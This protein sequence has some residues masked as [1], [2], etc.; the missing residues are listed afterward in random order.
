MILGFM[1][2]KKSTNIMNGLIS[3]LQTGKSDDIIKL[4]DKERQ[5]FF[6]TSDYFQLSSVFSILI[7]KF[8]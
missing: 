7:I 8:R 4:S 2:V 6:K 5:D 1:L 3:F